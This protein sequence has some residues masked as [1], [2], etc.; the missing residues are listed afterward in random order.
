ML[1]KTLSLIAVLLLVVGAHAQIDY[2]IV[3]GDTTICI[4]GSANL[5]LE[6]NASSIL[7]TPVTALSC[8]TC[9]N[10]IANPTVSTDYTATLANGTAIVEVII[11]VEVSEPV[12]LNIVDNT[13]ICQNDSLLMGSTTVI[14]DATYSW[15]PQNGLVDPSD[16]NTYLIPDQTRT[17]AL[18][19]TNGACETTASTTISVTPNDVEFGMD[20]AFVCVPDDANLMVTTMPNNAFIEWRS[21][22]DSINVNSFETEMTVLHPSNNF[23]VYASVSNGACMHTDSVLVRVD[24]LPYNLGILPQDSII[25]KGSTVLLTS[26]N[27]EPA[28]FPDATYFWMPPQG[29]QSG[30]SLLNLVVIPD[31]TRA[32]SRITS[33]GGCL[34]TSSTT[35]IVIQPIDISI[36]PQDPVI[37]PGDE[38]QFQVNTAE[39]VSFMWTTGENLSCDDCP[40]PTAT[41]TA[42]GMYTVE[43]VDTFG[44]TTPAMSNVVLFDE[45]LLRFPPVNSICGGTELLLN[46]DTTAHSG[47]TYQ[48]A[49]DPP[50][51]TLDATASNPFVIP[52]QS[53]TYSVTVTNTVGDCPPISA[54]YSVEVL[55]PNETIS[56]LPPVYCDENGNVSLE[57]TTSVSLEFA[58][59][60]WSNNASGPTTSVL[61]NANDT[62]TYFV[63]LNHACGITQDQVQVFPVDCNVSIPNAFTPNN[64][65]TNDR[66]NISL[67]R[68]RYNVLEFKVYNRWGQLVYDNESEAGWDGRYKDNDAPSDVYLYMVNYQSI[69]SEEI[70]SLRGDVTLL[71]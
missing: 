29:H 62:T 31:S 1:R 28:D 54:S 70:L 40:N 26:E 43:A 30:D 67:D 66:F 69:G 32:Y 27:H 10:P 36:S 45:G 48:W 6:T 71:R 24:S 41:P 51:A 49:A 8:T 38:I 9:P 61:S 13:S 68:T 53:T 25:C 7:W 59:I 57:V 14:A 47:I 60:S 23:S 35:V 16:P 52:S 56:I 20:T 5:V 50:D 19:A 37:C 55:S 17:Y 33:V 22:N 21:S 46:E 15:S 3:Q 64:D 58:D 42:S 63:I 44:C 4:G 2:T 34:D 65:G 18:T 11:S 12:A 39:D